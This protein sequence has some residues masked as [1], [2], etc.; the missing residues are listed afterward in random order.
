MERRIMIIDDDRSLCDR[1]TELFRVLGYDAIAFTDGCSALA[2]MALEAG[3]SRLDA[4]LLDLNMPGMKGM[5]VLK[6]MSI[7]HPDV[8]VIMVSST[9]DQESTREAMAYGAKDWIQKPIDLE[10]LKDKLAMVFRA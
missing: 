9:L 2:T 7:R 8:P 10:L 1:L 5:A 3:R 6:E 4:V